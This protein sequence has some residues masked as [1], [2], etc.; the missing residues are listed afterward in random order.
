MRQGAGPMADQS[1]RQFV[2]LAAQAPEAAGSMAPIGPRDEI[3]DK[4]GRANTA[5]EDAE[6]PD[7]LYGPGIRIELTPGQDPVSQMLMTITEEEI[8]WQ[9]I[10]RLLNHFQ[11][12]LLD[13]NTGQELGPST[14]QE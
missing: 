8:A 14:A 13:P 9:V 3:L 11:W 7:I 1:S 4:L 6:S 2:I 5:A 10:R 12:R